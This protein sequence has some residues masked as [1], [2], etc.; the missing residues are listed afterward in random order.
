MSTD[1]RRPWNALIHTCCCCLRLFNAPMACSPSGWSKPPSY[2]NAFRKLLK[3]LTA[4]VVGPIWST[5]IAAILTKSLRP[6]SPAWASPA[7]H[8]LL[9]LK[10]RTCSHTVW[11]ANN[12][13]CGLLLP[14]SCVVVQHLVLPHSGG[15]MPCTVLGMSCTLRL[16][17]LCQRRVCW[18][19]D[20]RRSCQ[21]FNLNLFPKLLEVGPVEPEVGRL[22]P[23]L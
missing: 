17:N 22:R 4:Y 15:T 2:S 7:V 8:L 16:C 14:A 13:A 18:S 11:S 12:P 23:F 20:L 9:R 19:P 1:R 5:N 6:T 3:Y 10:L 21:L